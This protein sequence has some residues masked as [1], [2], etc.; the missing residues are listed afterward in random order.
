MKKVGKGKARVFVVDDHPILRQGLAALVNQQPDLMICGEADD[1]L[2]ALKNM[3]SSKPDVLIVD[4]SLK[5][6]DGIELIKRMKIQYPDLAILV[7]SMHDESLYAERVLRAGARG[8]VMKE[9][10]TEEMVRSIRE[11]LNGEIAVSEKVASHMVHKLIESGSHFTGSPIENLT[12][13]ELEVFRLIGQGHTTREIAEE[14]HLSIKTIQAYRELI[15]KKLK[16]KNSTE[17]VRRAV[18]CQKTESST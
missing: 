7:V 2:T 11:V 14:L 6:M 1:A 17:L 13:R 18:E 16:L 8:F 4:I 5:G 3:A 9:E 12:D 10:A 15:K